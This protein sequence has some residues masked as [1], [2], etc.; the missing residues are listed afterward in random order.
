MMKA[1]CIYKYQAYLNNEL[2]F[3]CLGHTKFYKLCKMHFNISRS[4]ADKIINNTWV[5]KFKKYD[6]IKTLKIIRIHNS[7]STNRDECNGVGRSLEPLEV[8]SNLN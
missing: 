7:V 6:N 3:E 1:V 2:I 5:P 8:H 4:I